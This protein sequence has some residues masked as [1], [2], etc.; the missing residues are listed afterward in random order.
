MTQTILIGGKPATLPDWL[1]PSGWSLDPKGY[2]CYT[3]RRKQPLIKRGERAHRVIVKALL[4]RPLDPEMHVHHQSGNKLDNAPSNL[5]YMPACFN[6]TNARKCPYTGR[7]M[8]LQE[9][10]KSYA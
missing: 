3:S 1:P 4:G 6:P 9:W 7:Y 8:S 2:A 10:K 5:V